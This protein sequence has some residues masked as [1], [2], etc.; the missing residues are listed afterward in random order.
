[1]YD[2]QAD[3]RERVNLA[4]DPQ[5]VQTVADLKSRLKEW[6]AGFNRP[7]GEFTP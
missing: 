3:P 4:K 2:L 5:H 7:F 1:L 6:L